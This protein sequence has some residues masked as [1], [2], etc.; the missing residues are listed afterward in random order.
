MNFVMQ[1]PLM[2]IAPGSRPNALN[3]DGFVQAN[4]YCVA[5]MTLRLTLSYVGH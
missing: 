5:G 1:L 4:G 3:P 2:N